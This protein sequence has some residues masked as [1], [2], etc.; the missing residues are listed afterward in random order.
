MLFCDV[1]TVFWDDCYG[2]LS[3]SYCVLCF[4]MICV[5]FCDIVTVFCDVFHS[6]L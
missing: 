5:V 4:G 6:V 1:V 3:C 2:V